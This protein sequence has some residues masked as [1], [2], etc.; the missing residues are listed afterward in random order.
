VQ[1]LDRHISEVKEG[2]EEKM[3]TVILVI[4]H[5]CKLGSC[6]S[7]KPFVSAEF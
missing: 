6:I 3:I 4:V 7:N 1:I 2:E 5:K